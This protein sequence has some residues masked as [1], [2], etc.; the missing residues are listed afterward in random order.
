MAVDVK[1]I[2]ATILTVCCN[3]KKVKVEGSWKHDPERIEEYGTEVTHGLCEDCAQAL[4]P[5]YFVRIA[6]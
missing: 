1:D 5:K 2:K 4:Y 3:C 6:S